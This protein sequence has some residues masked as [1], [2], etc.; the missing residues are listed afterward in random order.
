MVKG[1]GF[2][3]GGTSLTRKR[4]P[5][6]LDCRSVFNGPSKV[7]GGGRSLMSEVLQFPGF[8][9]VVRL[10]G[11]VRGSSCEKGLK[12]RPFRQRSLLHSMFSTCDIEELV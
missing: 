1:L 8:L 10:V 7:I 11:N 3:V 9:L 12:L 5:Q 2:R 6:G 4:F